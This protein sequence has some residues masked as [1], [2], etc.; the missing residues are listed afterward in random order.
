M[1]HAFEEAKDNKKLFMA[2]WDVKD[3]FW[4]MDCW[5]GEHWNFAYL[6]LQ[7][8]GSP[9][10]LVI[11]SLLQMGWVESPPFFCAATK[12]IHDIAISTVTPQLAC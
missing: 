9:V 2:K 8:L 11:P 12:T 7:P 6:L 3:G 5:E 1:I 4:R 10:I